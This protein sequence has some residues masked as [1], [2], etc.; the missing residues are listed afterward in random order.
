MSTKRLNS[1]HL[2]AAISIY[3]TSSVHKH[4]L[5]STLLRSSPMKIDSNAS[6]NIL[7]SYMTLTDEDS[8]FVYYN[9]ILIVKSEVVTEI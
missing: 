6:S 3:I 9:N 8:Y 4:F 1:P 2:V 5:L 7:V